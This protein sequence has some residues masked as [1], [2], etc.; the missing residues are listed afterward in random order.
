MTADSDYD[1]ESLLGSRVTSQTGDIGVVFEIFS[2]EG[3]TYVAIESEISSD[4]I[5][6]LNINLKKAKQITRR[7]KK[8]EEGTEA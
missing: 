7:K 2:S 5:G 6:P 8:D 3:V 4:E 1:F